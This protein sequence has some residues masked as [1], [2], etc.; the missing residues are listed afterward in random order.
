MSVPATT[1]PIEAAFV[2]RPVASAIAATVAFVALTGGLRAAFSAI[3]PDG[4]HRDQIAAGLQQLVLA[5]VTVGVIA[6]VG[7]LRSARLTSRVRWPKSRWALTIVPAAIIPLAGLGAVDWAQTTQI[8]ASAF[9]FLTT[10]LVEEV[11]CRGFIMT[12]LAIGFRGRSHATL[13]VVL[14]SSLLFGLAHLNPIVVV[15]AAVFGFSFAHLAFATNTIWVGVVVHGAFDL[16]TDL[17]DSTNGS[18][19]WSIAPALA[20][21]LTG[22]IVAVLRARKPEI[23][24]QTP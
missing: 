18:T 16:F 7:W 10:G 1:H 12:G 21:V 15:F 14:W 6:Q 24:F 5:V 19:H 17:P 9:D 20:V 8:T 11:V 13:R 4:A 22:G 2:R 3:I 23:E